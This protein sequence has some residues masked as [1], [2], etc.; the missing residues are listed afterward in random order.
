[1]RTE[2][3]LNLAVKRA[4]RINVESEVNNM[5]F[6]QNYK[7]PSIDVSKTFGF[8]ITAFPQVKLKYRNL[9]RNFNGTDLILYEDGK[10]GYYIERISSTLEAKVNLPPNLWD[11]KTKD[12]EITFTY[13]NLGLK[14]NKRK[15]VVEFGEDISSL[16]N[17]KHKI[18]WFTEDG[19]VTVW[20]N[21]DEKEK[22]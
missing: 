2:I 16:I 8:E 9:E 19:D 13:T 20:K 21:S 1:M 12:S 7:S 22:K 14:Y 15:E 17:W 6:N 10:S 3:T 11:E 4:G 18:V 5:S